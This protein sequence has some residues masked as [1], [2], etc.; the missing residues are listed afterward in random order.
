MDAQSSGPRKKKALK[1]KKGRGKGPKD[2]Q[3][4]SEEMI[5]AEK[6]FRILSDLHKRLVPNGKNA[7]CKIT[8][9]FSTNEDPNDFAR[10]LIDTFRSLRGEKCENHPFVKGRVY[11]YNCE[12][13]ICEHSIPPN[14]LSVFAGYA[15]TGFPLW[16]ELSTVLLDSLDPR[17]DI[18]MHDKSPEVVAVCQDRD[19][20]RK[21]QLLVFGK[22]SGLY[23]IVGQVVCGYL[24]IP[25]GQQNSRS[26]LTI[27]AVKRIVMS[28]PKL[29]LNIIGRLPNNDLITD[30]LI[31]EPEIE[32]NGIINK[33]A[34]KLELIELKLRGNQHNG[35]FDQ[36]DN[37][38]IP[39]LRRVARGLE[40]IYRR[41][42]RR[43]RHAVQRGRHRPAVGL[44]LKD[45]KKAAPDNFFFDE[46]RQTIIVLGPKWRIHVFCLDGRHVTSMTQNRDSVRKR[47]D[48]K[49]WRYA[50]SDE[51]RNIKTNASGAE[52]PKHFGE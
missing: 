23:D 36:Y 38:T 12:S 28:K 35:D 19:E 47:I 4:F 42:K 9:P 27:Q 46:L 10:N 3:S 13:S 31:K 17:I 7:D 34:K 21:G 25:R 15:P 43:T 44:A 32:F 30:Y 14:H 45:L 26:A 51:I 2:K 11:C 52:N 1:K 22:E 5:R 48:L 29:V 24:P 40:R 33:A 50:N 41:E 8:L 6:V 18:I 39:I 20:L 37:L 16:E 49:K